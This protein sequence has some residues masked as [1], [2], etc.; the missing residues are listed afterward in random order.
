MVTIMISKQDDIPCTIIPQTNSRCSII[1]AIT[2]AEEDFVSSGRR[3]A[4][5]GEYSENGTTTD[6]DDEEDVED[7]EASIEQMVMDMYRRKSAVS[8][9]SGI[10]SEVSEETESA[11]SP[12]RFGSFTGPRTSEVLQSIP[13]PERKPSVNIHR[14]INSG[15]GNQ[16]PQAFD[17][18]PHLPSRRPSESISRI[19][20]MVSEQTEKSTLVELQS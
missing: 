19:Q 18:I 17:K 16:Y 3:R 12:D 8:A 6:D 13:K 7:I 2:I 15:Q 11:G 5:R 14:S 9:L 10:A 1:S 4:S 20:S